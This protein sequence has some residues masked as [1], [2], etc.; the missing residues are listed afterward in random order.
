MPPISRVVRIQLVVFAILAVFV[1]ATLG[2][3]YL[4][5]PSLVGIGQYKLYAD[6]PASGGLYKSANVTYRGITIGKVTDVEPTE[7]G[8]RAVMSISD[9]Y[10]IPV[11]S[12]A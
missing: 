6:L 3:Y 10:K 7:T 5:V 11:D 4:Q 8:A 1:L 2:W 12:S 9:S